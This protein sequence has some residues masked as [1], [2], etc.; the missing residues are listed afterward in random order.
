MNLE[1]DWTATMDKE[2]R[3]WCVRMIEKIIYEYDCN[4]ANNYRA[5]RMWKSSQKRRFRR[6]ESKGCCGSMNFVGKRLRP[7]T[8]NTYDLYLLGFN[9]GH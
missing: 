6:D 4:C 8:L 7:G 2:E 3:E 9:Y 1:K 5:A